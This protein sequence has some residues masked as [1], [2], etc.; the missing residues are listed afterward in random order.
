MKDLK[1]GFTLIEMMVVVIVISLMAMMVFKIA[2]LG[3]NQ[4]NVAATKTKV[5]KVCDAIEQFYAEFGSYPP[6]RQYEGTQPFMYEYNA[7]N[8]YDDG[9]YKFL[10]PG[11]ANAISTTILHDGTENAD[12]RLFTFGLM[13]FLLL[14]CGGDD[15]A[16]GGKQAAGSHQVTFRSVQWKRFNKE[17]RYANQTPTDGIR[18]KNAVA[19]WYPAIED[20]VESHWI[21]NRKFGTSHTYTNL[22]KTVRDSWGHDLHYES[23]PPHQSY[24]VW[25]VGKDGQD[26]TSDDVN[27]SVE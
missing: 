23:S 7:T 21:R 1:H 25:S 10:D 6:V 2:G 26:G 11:V 14:R 24:R 13:S 5:V 22:C 8:T 3:T 12:G 15:D 18:D 17:N 16:S 9:T 27:Q 19:K 20:I 4:S